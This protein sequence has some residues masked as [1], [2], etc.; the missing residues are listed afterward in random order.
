M[1][2]WVIMRTFST[3]LEAEMAKSLMET[4]G[5]TVQILADD[6]GGLRPDL[7]AALGAKLLVQVHELHV[8]R[9]LLEQDLEVGESGEE[10]E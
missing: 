2:D 9:Q 8:A 5:L 1:S 6:L 7:T 10:G 4:H 3:R